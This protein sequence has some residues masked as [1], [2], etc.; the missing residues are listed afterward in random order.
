VPAITRIFADHN[1][2]RYPG[3]R[4]DSESWLYAYSFSKELQD[5]WNWS[6]RFPAQP[7]T[8]AYL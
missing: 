5:E 4:T 6:E 8:Q 1:W 2:N 7:E 3:A